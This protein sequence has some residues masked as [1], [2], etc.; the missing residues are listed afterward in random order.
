MEKVGSFFVQALW[1]PFPCDLPSTAS[2]P[3][4]PPRWK[5]PLASSLGVNAEGK[6]YETPPW[7]R[8]ALNFLPKANSSQQSCMSQLCMWARAQAHCQTDE[9]QKDKKNNT[10]TLH[11]SGQF[12]QAS[13]GISVNP[14]Y[15]LLHLLRGRSP[16]K[17]VVK[18][19]PG[20]Q[21]YAESF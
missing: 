5:S 9:A 15:F 3:H 14:F 17:T 20:M 13:T 6:L 21:K 12:G 10:G 16:S 1:L 11:T 18:K 4:T 19:L 2:F 8:R 7:K